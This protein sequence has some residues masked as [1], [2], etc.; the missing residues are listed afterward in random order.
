MRCSIPKTARSARCMSAA[1]RFR[2][3]SGRAE[4]DLARRLSVDQEPLDHLRLLEIR[5]TAKAPVVQARDAECLASLNVGALLLVGFNI[6]ERLGGLLGVCSASPSPE[7]T[8]DLHL[9]LKLVS[10]SSRAAS[11]ASSCSRICSPSKSATG[12]SRTQQTMGSGTTTFARTRC[13]SRRAGER[14][15]ATGPQS[16]RMAPAR[17]SRRYGAS[18]SRAPRAPGGQNDLFESVHRMQHASGEWRWIQSRV[19]GRVD[20]T[21]G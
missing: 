20:E 6:R 18:P 21:A 15:W 13:I 5:D 3:Q 1:R 2:L 10:V 8:A 12:S 14:C 19:K 7:W 11:S 16:A 17:A 4:R 9:A